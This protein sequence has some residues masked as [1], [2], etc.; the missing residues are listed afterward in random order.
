MNRLEFTHIEERTLVHALR[1][2]AEAIGDV[3]YLRRDEERLTF[4]EVERKTNALAAGL[5]DLGVRPGDRVA[6]YM[7]TK[8]EM[9]LSAFAINKLGAVWVPLNTDYKGRWLEDLVNLCRVKVLIT[10]AAMLP[11]LEEVADQISYDQ[12]VVVGTRAEARS[13]SRPAGRFA[14]LLRYPE[15]AHDISGVGYGD[16]SAILW[17]S[18]TTGKSKGVMQPHNMWLWKAGSYK[19]AF[20]SRPGDVIYDVMPTYNSA[21]WGTNIFRALIDGITCACD[22]EFSVSRFWDRIRHYGATQTFTL[23]AM[24]IFLWQAPPRPDDADNP[25]REATMVPMP[26]HLIGPFRERFGI[27]TISQRFGQSE[28][29]L[30]FHRLNAEDGGK[31]N[32]LGVPYPGGAEVRLLDDNGQEVPAGVV[33]E[34]CARPREP[35]TMFNG[36]F[37]N[38]EATR[39]TY[40]GDWYRTGDLGLRD[41]D[42][43]YFFVDRKRDAIRYKGRNISTLEVEA[44]VRQHP[45]VADVAAFGVRSEALSAESELKLDVIIK[46]DA[47]LSFDALARFINDNAPYYFVPRYIEFVD[48]LPY[49]PTRKVQKFQLREKGV[50]AAAWDRDRSGF[51]VRR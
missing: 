15:A 16:T 40:F 50:T 2:Q 28:I 9:I 18:G 48:E 37:D 8:L 20:R 3:T 47:E 13:A 14:D 31:P 29:S 49:T 33:G 46:P 38:P 44:V 34:I 19:E 17:T 42:G 45:A 43:D 6:L 41:E 21:A 4:S 27:E 51:V 26:E 30:L 36:Y 10:D 24:H 7:K 35:F 12:L 23:G 32:S 11:R 22:P 1:R 39:E 5:K 25:L